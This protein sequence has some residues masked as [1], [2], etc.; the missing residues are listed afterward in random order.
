MGGDLDDALIDWN[1]DLEV[2]LFHSLR[3][4][5]PTGELFVMKLKLLF[6]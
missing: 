6:W 4:H 5:R 3:G 2:N 1:A